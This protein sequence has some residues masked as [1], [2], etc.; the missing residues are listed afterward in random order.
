LNFEQP[1]IAQIKDHW[2]VKDKELL[3]LTILTSQGRVDWQKGASSMEGLTKGL[4][5]HSRTVRRTETTLKDCQKDS[6]NIEGLESLSEG[7]E[8]H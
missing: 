8:Q 6:N 5:Q 7:L 1:L 4:E 3:M 2:S